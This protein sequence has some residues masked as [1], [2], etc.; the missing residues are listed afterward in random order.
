MSLFEQAESK[1]FDRA[2]PLAARMRPRNLN[3]FFGQKH[4]LAEGKL[5]WRLI[6]S[7]RL[8]S[9]LFYGPPGCGK[10][11]LAQLLA[12][13]TKSR[14]RQLNAV[15]SG[16]KELRE[17]LQEAQSEVA[18]GG[19]KTLLF[20][21]EIHRFNKSQQDALLPDVE[22]GIV[23][24]VGATTSNP[25]FAVNSALV[26]RSQV[27][28]FEPLSSEEIREV[29]DAALKDPHRGLGKH[30]VVLHNEAAEFLAEVCDGDARRALNALEIGVLS[31]DE[32]PIE[33]TRELA[34]ETIQR[35]A[36][37]YD[38]DGD[39]HYDTASA[40]IKSIRGSDVDA[41]I[42]WLAKMLEGGED[43]RFITRRL[44]ISASEDIGNADPHALT[45][46]VSAMQAC[47]MI[48]LPECQLTLSQTVAYLACA[49]KSNAATVAIGEARADIREGRVQPVPTHL[50]DAHYGGAKDLGHGEGYQYAHN[51]PDGIAAQS[52]LGI[53]R[54]YY[55]PVP[56]GF[57]AT[58]QKRVEV[59]RKRLRGEDD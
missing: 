1:N 53:D 35:K 5:L 45:I 52:Y 25:F 20:I 50:R 29:L 28:Q 23:I 10:T 42:Y 55:R 15:T 24:L 19:R 44:I 37:Q 41:S 11:T 12:S 21:D 57:E 31:S 8:T 2:K 6:K 39:T 18:T 27:F 16:V 56:R 40:L 48:G 30:D 43:I 34:E 32:K 59:Y 33:F 51:A 54:E 7:N 38:R 9:V 58:L 36:V 46:A 4:F 49:P 14:Y 26:S 3:E 47:E 13:E 17:V 22:N